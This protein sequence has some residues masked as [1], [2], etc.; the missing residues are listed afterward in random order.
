[1][2]KSKIFFSRDENWH[3]STPLTFKNAREVI[4]VNVE[5]IPLKLE[6]KASC[7]YRNVYHICYAIYYDQLSSQ[8]S[9]KR[10]KNYCPLS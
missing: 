9:N 8:F 2:F 7:M 1:M 3:S 5:F 10:P 4:K 6:F